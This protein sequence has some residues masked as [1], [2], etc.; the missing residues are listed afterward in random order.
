MFNDDPNGALVED[1]SL[2]QTVPSLGSPVNTSPIGE[3]V[4]RFSRKVFVGGLPPDIDEGTP[5]SFYS[6]CLNNL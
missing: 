5:F 3:R 2:D 1:T 6:Y 4:E